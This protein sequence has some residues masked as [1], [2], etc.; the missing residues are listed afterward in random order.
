MV[1]AGVS[2]GGVMLIYIIGVVV[3]FLFIVKC[4]AFR[5]LPP[6]F[7]D[8]AIKWIKF[9]LVWFYELIDVK[10]EPSIGVRCLTEVRW[11]NVMLSLS[12]FFTLRLRTGNDH[13]AC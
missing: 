3:C 7:V 5:V 11:F 13:G 4:H 1:L 6:L 12:R 9:R 10:H 8:M 2:S